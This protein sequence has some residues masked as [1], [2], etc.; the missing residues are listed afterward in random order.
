MSDKIGI[1]YWCEGAGHAARNL[2][3][4]S[5]MESRGAEV[6]M[7]GG[8]PGR[9]FV[10]LNDFEDPVPEPVT[11]IEKKTDSEVSR[12][13]FLVDMLFEEIPSYFKRFKDIYKW[14]GE[15]QPDKI[16]TDDFLAVIA[17]SVK[18]VEFYRIEHMTPE[19]VPLQVEIPLRIY[20]WLTL[21]FGEKVFITSV[22]EIDEER[23]GVE[24]V[25]PLAQEGDMEVES[26]DVLLIPGTMS[27]GFDEIRERLEDNGLEVRMVG[28]ED[29]ELSPAMTP[30]TEAASCVVCT[31]F[32]SIADTVVPG[33]P[34]VVF[35]FFS[36]QK[37]IAEEIEERDLQGF[38][39]VKTKEQA[40]EAAERFC[41]GSS[42]NPEASN[43][44]GEVAD[45]VL[46]S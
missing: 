27:E 17:A 25:G 2:A 32:S 9:K 13:R 8:G 45:Q 4:A 31:G 21:R 5:E 22:W 19:I 30:Y 1:I 26:F 16:V 29:W 15:E 38:E 20:D 7:A 34:C 42:E 35:P 46:E 11:T 28:D 3:I 6:L 36:I 14:I 44:A 40:V 43:G 41:R 37:S 10:E 39:Y 24:G 18:G 23:E 12:T 33:T